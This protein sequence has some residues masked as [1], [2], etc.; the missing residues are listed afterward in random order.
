MWISRCGAVFAVF[1]AA[2]NLSGQGERAAITGTITDSTQ[3]VVPGAS[4]AVRNVATNIVTRTESNSEGIY[5]A[6][7][8]PPG[9]YELTAEKQGFRPS[10]TANIPLSVNLTATINVVLE[11][12][13]VAE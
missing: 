1:L 3:A 9:Q 11:V 2:S 4:I 6:T 8:L 12:G 7:S 10:R 13:T 5:Y